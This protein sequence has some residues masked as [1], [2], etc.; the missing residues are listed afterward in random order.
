MCVWVALFFVAQKSKLCAFVV[1]LCVF[2]S[3][4]HCAF[5]VILCVFTQKRRY[6]CARTSV[7]A[8]NS[9]STVYS[10]FSFKQSLLLVFDVFFV[11]EHI[12]K[13]LKESTVIYIYI[14][15]VTFIFVNCVK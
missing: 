5:A 6:I 4:V 8:L 9:V 2:S 13:Y 3:C 15:T 14:I 1:I 7:R 10:I 12:K 11:R